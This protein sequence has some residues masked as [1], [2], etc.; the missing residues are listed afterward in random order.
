[1]I[2]RII[3]KENMKY[4]IA[5]IIP[6]F[7]KWPEWIDLYFYS[8]GQNPM[9]DFIFY[10]DC[11]IP[12]NEHNN[13]F[14]HKCT[15]DE[16]KSFVSKKLCIDFRHNSTYKLTDLKPFLGLIHE[17]E[18]RDYDFWAFGDV[19]LVYGDLSN[20]INDTT[21]TKY[22]IITTHA[23]RIAGHLCIVRNNDYY[24]NLC[25]KI[26]DWQVGLCENRHYAYD[27]LA[28]SQLVN[29]WEHS[30]SRLYR[31]FLC[32]LGFNRDKVFGVMNRLLYKKIYNQELL[33][34]PYPQP[35]S[36]EEEVNPRTWKYDL[37]KGT[38]QS[39]DGT[40]LPYLHFM[41]FKKSQYVETEQYWKGNYYNVEIPFEQYKCIRFNYTGVFGEK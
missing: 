28:W 25:L 36:N 8:C 30:I 39:P 21:L 7:G 24:R 40:V 2:L 16:Y 15:F 41:A 12:T 38:I 37:R 13:L 11:S 6:Y 5:Q 33:T 19:D 9:I 34:T 3:T 20:W 35:V 31:Y 29:T 17:R 10:T 1:M 14:F 32:Y 26:K 27:E 22:D 4:K 23:Y 18:L